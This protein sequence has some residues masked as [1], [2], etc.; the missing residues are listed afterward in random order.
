M[1]LYVYASN[2]IH[3]VS[4]CYKQLIQY[5]GN[6]KESVVVI[7][8]VYDINE[9]CDEYKQ[10]IQEIFTCHRKIGYRYELI[11]LVFKLFKVCKTE[12]IN[13]IFFFCT[14]NYVIY[15]KL[16]ISIFKLDAFIYIHD[17][18]VHSGERLKIKLI[19][20]ILDAFIVKKAKG[21]IVSYEEGRNIVM[22]KYNKFSKVIWLPEMK[23]MEFEEIRKANVPCEYDCIFFGR[24]EI[25][26]GIDTLLES[27][28]YIKEQYNYDLKLAIVGKGP[29]SEDIKRLINEN[30]GQ[31][32]FFNSYVEDYELAKLIKTSKLVVLPYRDATGTQ[33]IQTANYYNKPVIASSVGAFKEYIVN[34]VNGIVI[35]NI[36]AKNLGDNVYELLNND[37][38]Y[39]GMVGSIDAYF[40]EHFSVITFAKEIEKFISKE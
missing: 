20:R 33:T 17:P 37:K 1:V 28:K 14:S 8:S 26:K 31:I 29:E 34:Y 9:F 32:K 22:K 12:K 18:K 36:S 2:E 3:A 35:D 4:D 10:K 5:L 25:Y 11:K 7:P 19:R 30:R 13:K 16:L 39:K 24:I 23:N 38:K 6:K 27:V 15:F 40:K 21:L